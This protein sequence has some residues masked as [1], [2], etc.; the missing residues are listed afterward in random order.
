MTMQ[1]DDFAA[2][3][4]R[5]GWTLTRV[6]EGG[7]FLIHLLDDRGDSLLSVDLATALPDFQ[8]FAHW[9]TAGW[10]WSQQ[11]LAYFTANQ[12]HL[13]VRAWWGA[14]LVIALDQLRPIDL[15]ELA[16]ELAATE[17]EL[18]MRELRRLVARIEGGECPYDDEMSTDVTHCT[19][20][21]LAHF[22]GLLSLTDAIPLL[23][24][25]KSERTTRNSAAAHSPITP[26]PSGSSRR[27]R[28]GDWA[29]SRGA[30][31]C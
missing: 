30:S 13:V 15:R 22:P 16:D 24:V 31:R 10:A 27:S 3:R 17:S 18:V 6:P 23:R 12:R 4:S 2:R 26:I 14:R 1:F 11:M 19:V 21:T 7:G 9:T 8:R 20:G 25:L 5:G 28:C 29:R